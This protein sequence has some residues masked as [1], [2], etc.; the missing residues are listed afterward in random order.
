MSAPVV[1]PSACT[2]CT[3]ARRGH[4]R[5]YA[6]A[7]G[8]HEWAQPSQEQILTRMKA[9]RLQLAVARAGAL[10]VPAGGERTLDVVEE[11][12]TGVNLALWEEIEAYARL[13][14]A[15]AAA[16]RDRSRLRARVAELLAE[17]HSTN[18]ALDDAV[19]ALRAGSEL[20]LPW[21]H[22]MPDGDLSGFLNDLVS[23]AMGRWRSE[24]EV[25]DR[26]VLA[27][28]EKVCADWRTPGE[29]YRSDPEP[30]PDA[31]SKVFVPVAS[32]REP[33][34]EHYP[35]VHHD[36]RPGLGR[37]LPETGGAQGAEPDEDRL[38]DGDELRRALRGHLFGGGS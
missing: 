37:D 13:R 34:G 36:Y 2:W 12:L 11:E 35:V 5:Q 31:V 32:L 22:E 3:I 27:D 14:L 25:P 24:P 19:Q 28:I 29:G 7:V 38:L 6:D 8:W 23:A 21:A 26:T 4:G 20:A 17:R 1:E 16:K 33:E 30:M 10:P 9:R 18:E 15:L